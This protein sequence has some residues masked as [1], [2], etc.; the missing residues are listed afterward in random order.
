MPERFSSL[1]EL[2]EK[3]WNKAQGNDDSAKGGRKK[4]R[5]KKGAKKRKTRKRKRKRKKT[6]RKKRKGGCYPNCCRKATPVVPRS[7]VVVDDVIDLGHPSFDDRIR[8][9]RETI[10]QAY[11]AAY[12]PITGRPHTPWSPS[13]FKMIRDGEVKRHNDEVNNYKNKYP[14]ATPVSEMA[15]SIIPPDLQHPDIV[16]TPTVIVPSTGGGLF[17]GKS[18]I[19][20]NFESGNINHI[21]NVQ[22]KTDVLVVLEIEN[23]PYPKNTKKT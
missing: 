14:R 20:T 11:D 8:T 13:Q 23:E 15:R 19:S 10:Q 22:R 9:T 18:T 3:L 5:R 7:M 21:K 6:R 4:T 2:H 1:K 16:Y 12:D 17:K